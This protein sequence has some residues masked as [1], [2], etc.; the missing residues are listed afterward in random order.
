MIVF[1][2][3][4]TTVVKIVVW[5]FSKTL[6]FVIKTPSVGVIYGT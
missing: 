5:V 3:K 4:K 2:S 6:V 1:F